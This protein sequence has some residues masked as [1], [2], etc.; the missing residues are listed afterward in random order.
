MHLLKL[1]QTSVTMTNVLTN[2]KIS[3]YLFSNCLIGNLP[4][5]EGL[6]LLTCQVVFSC[7]G[8]MLG[9]L[10]S[11]LTNIRCDLASSLRGPEPVILRG[12]ILS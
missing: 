9:R 2:F 12:H 3:I 1:V 5:F 8:R 7:N 10:K 6:I 11:K 4:Y